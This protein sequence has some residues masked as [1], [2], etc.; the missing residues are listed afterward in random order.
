MDEDGEISQDK[1]SFLFKIK[2]EKM[3]KI[4]LKKGYDGAE[5]FH[6]AD[7]LVYFGD[8]LKIDSYCN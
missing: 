2:K 3:T 8:D 4:E 5:V 6:S 1:K 7:H